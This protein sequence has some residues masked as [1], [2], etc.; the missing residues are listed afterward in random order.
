LREK[1]IAAFTKRNSRCPV[2][3][4]VDRNFVR[5]IS[6][7]SGFKSTFNHWP[8]KVRV[9]PSFIKELKEAMNSADFKKMTSKIQLVSDDS[10]PWDGLYI[11]EDAEGNTYDLMKNGHGP[12]Q[13][14]VLDWLGIQWPDYYA[15]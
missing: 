8:S 4:G 12:S 13:K 10:N 7:I 14:D 9:D 15:D 11:S 6:C 5:F 2:P 3:N 1:G